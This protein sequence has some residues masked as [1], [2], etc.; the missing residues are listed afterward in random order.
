M[1][2][3]RADRYSCMSICM[4]I[5]SLLCSLIAVLQLTSVVGHA[6]VVFSAEHLMYS[7]S[8]ASPG[9][10][11]IAP[12]MCA[13]L[14]TFRSECCSIIFITFMS[15]PP[16]ITVSLSIALTPGASVHP[17]L[18]LCSFSA[19]PGL[20]CCTPGLP[21]SITSI[22]LPVFAVGSSGSPVHEAPIGRDCCLPSISNVTIFLPGSMQS[23]GSPF[24]WSFVSSV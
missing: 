2:L 21:S 1:Y 9:H 13:T 4:S 20:S 8:P 11:C 14:L 17:A 22:G 18:R 15:H 12:L 24:D 3:A 7:S 5:S 16:P 6:C 23:F 10:A 19:S